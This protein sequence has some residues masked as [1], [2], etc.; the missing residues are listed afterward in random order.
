MNIKLFLDCANEILGKVCLYLDSNEEI[1]RYDL[2]NEISID[3]D[4]RNSKISER[5]RGSERFIIYQ[6]ENKKYLMLVYIMD[7]YW[8]EVNIPYKD[9][10]QKE[11]ENINDIESFKRLIDR[12]S[13]DRYC[14]IGTIKENKFCFIEEKEVCRIY[15]NFKGSNYMLWENN[16]ADRKETFEMFYRFIYSYITKG[17]LFERFA[18]ILGEEIREDDLIKL[19]GYRWNIE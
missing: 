8:R 3:L 10:L 14:S 12:V 16:N 19:W 17:F 15:Y 7:L 13:P 5:E 6:T 2:D 1:I 11:F 4:F 18:E 9:I